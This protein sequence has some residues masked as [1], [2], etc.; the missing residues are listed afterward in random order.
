MKNSRPFTLIELL[1]VIAM[2]AIIAAMLLPALNKARER[3]R[4]TH[5]TGNLRQIGLGTAMYSAANADVLPAQRSWN[6]TFWVYDLAGAN[7]VSLKVFRCPT[8]GRYQPRHPTWGTTVAAV[9]DGTA[10]LETNRNAAQYACYGIN[11]N[12]FGDFGSAAAAMGK[13]ITG[14]RDASRVIFAAE[15]RDVGNGTVWY[16]VV[17]EYQSASGACA[18]PWHNGNRCNVLWADG[19]VTAALGSGASDVAAAQSLYSAA[20]ALSSPVNN[21]NLTPWKIR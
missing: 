16:Y 2:I 7:Y 10:R 6:G 11:R 15:S 20:G 12:T 21:P 14:I 8:S 5:C 9:W 3:S 4:A 1:V 17:Q 18:W 19:H 13:K